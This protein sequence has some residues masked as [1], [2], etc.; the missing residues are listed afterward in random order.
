M[1]KEG[2]RGGQIQS[3]RQ[4]CAAACGCWGRNL[5]SELLKS[6]LQPQTRGLASGTTHSKLEPGEVAQSSRALS[7]RTEDLSSGPGTHIKGLAPP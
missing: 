4:L 5:S 3:C 2:G 7:A 6:P 1:P